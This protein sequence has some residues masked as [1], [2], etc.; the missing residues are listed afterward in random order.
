MFLDLEL[1]GAVHRLGGS[2][3]GVLQSSLGRWG[4]FARIW[5][6]HDEEGLVKAA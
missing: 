3:G 5:Q 6:I 2:V 4:I 1:R